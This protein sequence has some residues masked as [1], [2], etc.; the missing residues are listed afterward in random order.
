LAQWFLKD[1]FK[2]FPIE[3]DEE[4]FYPIVAPHNPQGPW[5][6]Q[7]DSALYQEALV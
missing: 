1:I 5:I 6:K 4:T 3:V 2:D 7:I